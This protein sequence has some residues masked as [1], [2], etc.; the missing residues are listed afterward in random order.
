[1]TH[2]DNQDMIPEWVIQKIMEDERSVESCHIDRKNFSAIEMEAADWINMLI[3]SDL[4]KIKQAFPDAFNSIPKLRKTIFFLL[5][6]SMLR[7]WK[8]GEA[9]WKSNFLR[10]P[11]EVTHRDP[12]HYIPKREDF[13]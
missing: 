6:K 4:D 8:M 2:K 13:I 10:L 7:G 9:K 1:M 11:G 12:K 3:E 5:W